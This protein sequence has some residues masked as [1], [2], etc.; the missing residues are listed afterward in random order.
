MALNSHRIPDPPRI[1]L[2]IKEIHFQW[3]HS[4]NNNE[5][6]M[7]YKYSDALPPCY[8]YHASHVGTLSTRRE[9]HPIN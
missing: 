9:I 7:N 6:S 1:K 2:T 5:D 4:Q 8:S 3:N